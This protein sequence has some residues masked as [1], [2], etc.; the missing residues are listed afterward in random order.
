MQLKHFRPKTWVNTMGAAW[1]VTVLPLIIAT[2]IFL[3][4][5]EPFSSWPT[6]ALF[7][8]GALLGLAAA[9]VLYA[10]V[11]VGRTIDEYEKG[12]VKNP[13]VSILFYLAFVMFGLPALAG[14]GVMTL[15]VSGALHNTTIAEIE[16]KRGHNP[17]LVLSINCGYLDIARA[18]GMFDKARQDR[19]KYN[20]FVPFFGELDATYHKWCK[21]K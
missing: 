1:V 19:A 12:S 17:P 7:L 10:L 6:E 8:T 14:V 20:E 11:G 5:K 15:F 18:R 16:P 13:I 2:F 21:N 9:L 3:P 4:A